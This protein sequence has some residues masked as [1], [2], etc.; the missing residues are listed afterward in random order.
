MDSYDVIII[1]GSYAGLSAAM[2]L[3]R[4]LRKVLLI[5]A[6]EPCNR[7]TPHSHNFL[8]QDGETPAI[9]SAE[10]KAQVLAYP[11]VKFYDGLAIQ[12]EKIKQGFAISTADGQRFEARKLILAMGIKDVF[13]N[14]KGFA[15]CWGIS[16]L[17]CP[18]CHGYEVAKQPLGVIANGDMAFEFAKMIYNWS[19]ELTL[20]TNGPSTLSQ[21]QT[22]HFKAKNIKIV[23]TE[24]AE[25]VHWDGQLKHVLL[26]DG[27]RHELKA[28]FG[29]GSLEQHTPIAAQLGCTLD[30]QNLIIANDGQTSVPGVF[31]AG[32]CAMLFRS[33]AG[34][35][36][37]GNKAGVYANKELIEEDF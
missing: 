35:V 32:D 16:V 1:G 12:A 33:V 4:S 7:Q 21:A 2:A 36:A 34:A 6:G 27:T 3:G 23:S 19:P 20:F 30:Q 17:H 9:I 5:D 18:Y 25:L 11:T 24:I 28:V 22:E 37:M 14:I 13:P 29:R 8:T 26:K 31:A 15:E 10:A